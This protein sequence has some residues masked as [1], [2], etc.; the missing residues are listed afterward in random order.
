MIPAAPQSALAALD[1]RMRTIFR[2]I[3]EAYLRSGDP[4]GSRTLSQTGN[5]SL[6]PASIRNTMADLA[7]LGL[8]SAPHSSAG[9][10]P[11]HAGL[12]LFVDGLLQVGELSADER[13]AI[14]GQV[15]VSGRSTQDLLTEATSL[16]GGLAGGAGL[17]V[18]SKREA[19]LRHVEF[20]PLSAVEMLAVLVFEDGS[21]ENRLMR[22]PDGIPPAALIEAGNYLSTRLKGRTLSDA[23]KAIETEIAERRS[24]LDSAAEGLVTQGLADWSG[25]KG[26]ERSLI[27]RGQARLLESLEAAS[28]L[29]R[30]RLLFDDIERKEELITLLDKARDAQGVRLF[31][32]AEN[33]LFSL[34]GSSVIV[35]PYM[36]AEQEIIGA[37]GVIG[38]TR[39]NYARV[40]PLVD[41]TAR[42]V[43]QI[44]DGARS[45]E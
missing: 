5:L 33:P 10:M 17:V 24:A 35:A 3:V 21:V 43:G 29:E 20:V 11:T 34:S 22:S 42:V 27:V 14:E 44:L 32:G 7:D 1:D 4:V 45:R 12:R 26:Q 38:P 16:L 6:S 13:R 8:L 2:E 15:S 30:I 31:I 28:D 25:G 9:R 37:L 36:N 23:R 39:L 18:T 19:P 41:Y 40:I